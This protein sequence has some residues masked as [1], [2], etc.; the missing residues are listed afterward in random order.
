MQTILK[1]STER[2]L[3]EKGEFGSAANYYF[4]GLYELALSQGVDVDLLLHGVGLSK[5]LLNQSDKRIPTEKL[6]EFQKSIWD[7]MNDESM[8]VNS[9]PIH[10]GT[11]YMMGK[12]TVQQP[13]L[14]KALEL[15][16]RF[17]NLMLRRESVSLRSEDA[18]T[19]LTITLDDPKRDHNNLFAEISLLSW[20]RYASWLIAD[21]L[22]LS[23]T[24]FPFPAH[25]HV[26]E[27][28]YLFP[29]AHLFSCN[30]LAI[31]FPSHYLDREVKQSESALKVFMNRCPLEL[32]K[33]YKADY[34]LSSELK[35]LIKKE[36]HSGRAT[37]EYCATQLHMTTR[38]LMRKLKDE[39]TS[40]QKIKDLIRRDRAVILLSQK[41]IA[42]NEI[43]E[44]IGYSDP[45]VFTRAF[46]HWTGETPRSFR[47][48]LQ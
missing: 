22:P 32:F 11:Y 5:L 29:G 9:Q 42:I 2:V 20:H 18:Q 10:S 40:F 3:S 37:I 26:G 39:G 45:A 35:L 8:G 6:A 24:R 30:E 33:Q 12:L 28:N 27:Y 14:R 21:A 34:S 48:K 4:T 15:G 19:V 1:Q 17:Y 13:S 38:T 44:R 25:A 23:E 41:G 47:S 46:R 43:A 31:V 7:W 16:A 36:L